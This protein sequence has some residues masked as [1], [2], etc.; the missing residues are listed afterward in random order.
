[1]I[2]LLVY[3]LEMTSICDSISTLSVKQALVKYKD[4]SERKSTDLTFDDEMLCKLTPYILNELDKIKTNLSEAYDPNFHGF[5]S[6]SLLAN[7]DFIFSEKYQL[8]YNHPVNY[9]QTICD[10]YKS[11]EK[12]NPLYELEICHCFKEID[13]R[14]TD[15]I[16]FTKEDNKMLIVNLFSRTTKSPSTP[17]SLTQSKYTL[18][19]PASP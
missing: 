7:M 15:G 19:S 4:L 11:Y 13:D 16:R 6:V 9:L 1:M 8:I 5:V 10:L 2:Y 18:N 14:Y 3:I 17:D 12:E